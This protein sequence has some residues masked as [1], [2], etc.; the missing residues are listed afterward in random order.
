VVQSSD[1]VAAPG[2]QW[3]PARRLRRTALA[4]GDRPIAAQAAADENERLR[5][6]L[7]ERSVEAGQREEIGALSVQIEHLKAIVHR[8][9]H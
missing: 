6:K 8:Q 2:P 1:A 3:L 9:A 5:R 7:L 4:V